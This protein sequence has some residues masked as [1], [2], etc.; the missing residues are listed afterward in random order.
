LCDGWV[1][2]GSSNVDRWNLRW[3]LEGNQEIEDSQ[4]THD[5]RELFEVDFQESTECL[6]QD[7]HSRSWVGRWQ[8]WFW[9][10]VEDLLAKLAERLGRHKD[11]S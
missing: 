11:K 5:V 2:L 6:L 8:E 10:R 7:W 3:N 4:F 9:G 1:S